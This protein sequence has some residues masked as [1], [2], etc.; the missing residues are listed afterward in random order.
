MSCFRTSCLLAF[1]GEQTVSVCF[2][3]ARVGRPA[4]DLLVLMASTPSGKHASLAPQARAQRPPH[5]F[6]PP[7]PGMLRNG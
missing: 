4:K 2:D 1:D 5:E 3:A 6:P 7:L